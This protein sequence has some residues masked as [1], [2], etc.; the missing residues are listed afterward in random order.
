MVRD[1]NLCW[2]CEKRPK[3]KEKNA[4]FCSKCEKIRVKDVRRAEQENFYMKV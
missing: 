4:L 1:V 2:Y 3:K